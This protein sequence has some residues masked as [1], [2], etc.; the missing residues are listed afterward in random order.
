[1]LSVHPSHSPM[2]VI[3]GNSTQ[4]GTVNERGIVNDCETK[5]SER[6]TERDSVSESARVRETGTKSVND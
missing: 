1:M 6:V 3:V 2:P 4:R 5:K